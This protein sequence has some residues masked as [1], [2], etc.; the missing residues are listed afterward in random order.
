[1]A[2]RESRDAEQ[3]SHLLELLAV[4][5]VAEAPEAGFE[6]RRDGP[7]RAYGPVRAASRLLQIPLGAIHR[8]RLTRRCAPRSTS[9]RQ[10]TPEAGFEPA[11]R[12]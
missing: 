5:F 7:A 9:P 6:P 10:N 11:S 4:S 2:P 12:P 3:R 8:G 1:M